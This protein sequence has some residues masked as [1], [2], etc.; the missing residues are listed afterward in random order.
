MTSADYTAS[1]DPL[2]TEFLPVQRQCIDAAIGYFT[3]LLFL[4]PIFACIMY[5]ACFFEKKIDM[6]SQTFDQK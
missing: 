3:F 5:N 4:L 6:N 1:G 2:S